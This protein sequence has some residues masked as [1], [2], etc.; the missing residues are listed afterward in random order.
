MQDDTFLTVSEAAAIL[1]VSPSTLRNW[2]NAGRVPAF[3]TPGNQRRY[4]RRE[5]E[6]F[7]ESLREKGS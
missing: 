2:T 3:R 5:I 1:G 4:L 7:R 6:A